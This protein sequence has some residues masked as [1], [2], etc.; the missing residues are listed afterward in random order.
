M[1]WHRRNYVI[2]PQNTVRDL[3]ESSSEANRDTISSLLLPY[4]VPITHHHHSCNC[5]E[6]LLHR[7]YREGMTAVVMQHGSSHGRLYHI[8]LF[9][10]TTLPTNRV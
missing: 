3:E 10:Y 7:F 4:L 1:A 5:D 2:D 9:L 8:I 6:M